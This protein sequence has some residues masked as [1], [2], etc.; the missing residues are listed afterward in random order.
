MSKNAARARVHRRPEGRPAW[1]AGLVIVVALVALV[2]ACT[3][4]E[5]PVD[6]PRV[7]T[8]PRRPPPAQD[9]E[10][11]EE[12][13]ST[14]EEAAGSVVKMNTI[15][16][17]ILIELFDKDA[18]ITAGNFLL[19]V[20][21][22]YYNRVK[23]H[24]VEPGF[25]IQGGDP[26]GTGRGGPGF[27]IPDELKPELR[28]DRGTLSMANAGPDTGGS[29]FFIC[30]SRE[31]TKHLDMKHS[32]FGRVLEGMEVVDRIEKGDPMLEVTVE[33]ESPYAAAAKEAAR[34][35]RVPD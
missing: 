30:L 21:E 23:F 20:E 4:R 12:Q 34:Q 10:M 31:A 13:L 6:T 8:T 29:Q 25:V 17:K 22:G 14:I 35:A 27:T 5:T 24:R 33:R 1:P 7:D 26:T 9:A 15:K 3:P 18:P 28:H 2:G 16:G 32:V 11:P 19:L